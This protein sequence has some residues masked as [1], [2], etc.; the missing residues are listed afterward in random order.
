[1]AEPYP[2]CYL[3]G[4][5]LG[6][7]ERG[8]RYGTRNDKVR[9][10]GICAGNSLNPQFQLRPGESRDWTIDYYTGIYRNTVLGVEWKA[11]FTL[12]RLQLIPGNQVQT[13]G[14]YA[15]SFEN[16]TAGGGG[17][18]ASSASKGIL[19]EI[20]KALKKGK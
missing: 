17:N 19:G 8:N 9:G 1:M 10:I 2:L 6:T 5:A 7:D 14:D 11:D 16:L 12:Q 18:G 20:N 13:N 15:V 3:N 4:T